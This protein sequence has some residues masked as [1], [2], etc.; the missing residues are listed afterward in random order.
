MNRIYRINGAA[1]AAILFILSIPVGFLS[2]GSL[3]SNVEA[4][5]LPVTAITMGDL[6]TGEIHNCALL[7]RPNRDRLLRCLNGVRFDS[8]IGS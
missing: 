7:L 4:Y 2:A 6:N 8:S 5:E 3:H 1:I